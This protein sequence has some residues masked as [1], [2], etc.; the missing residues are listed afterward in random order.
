MKTSKV[1]AAALFL[2][3]GTMMFAGCSDSKSGSNTNSNSNTAT[4]AEFG[5]PQFSAKDINGN[6]HHT[7]EWFGKQPVVINFW[8][9]WCGPC[10]REIP[11]LAKLYQEY[12]PQ[13][14]E[15]ISIAVKDTPA[16]VEQYAA[17]NNMNW[18]LLMSQDQILIDY[19]ATQGIPTTVFI[20]K[21]GNEVVRF[22]GMRDYT[23]LKRA[24]EAIL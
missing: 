15:L 13:G 24:F 1:A 19:K 22:I 2:T 18:V 20:D 16:K 17:R 5:V 6:W 23:T 14:I 12:K 9:T 10:R 7:S 3:V 21:D 11:D 4:V 8:G